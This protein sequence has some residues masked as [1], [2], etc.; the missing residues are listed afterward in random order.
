MRTLRSGLLHHVVSQF[1][2]KGILIARRYYTVAEPHVIAKV[3][4]S[5]ARNGESRCREKD[6]LGAGFS[7]RL[8][9]CSDQQGRFAHIVR[10]RGVVGRRAETWFAWIASS[11]MLLPRN[12]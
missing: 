6:G 9:G 8:A 12:P 1:R 10:A 7:E 5:A 4:S 2:Y 3:R 11:Q